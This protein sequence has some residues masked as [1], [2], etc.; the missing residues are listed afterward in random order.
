MYFY[1]RH[2]PIQVEYLVYSNILQRG[3]E[4]IYLGVIHID[5]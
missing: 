2:N 3:N 1:Q 4:K 5:A